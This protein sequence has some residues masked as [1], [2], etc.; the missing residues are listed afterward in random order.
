LLSSSGVAF[1]TDPP[2]DAGT[3]LSIGPGEYLTPSYPGASSS[4]GFL[5]PY[6]DAEY[7][8]RLY[9]NAS[10]L[11]GVY[12]YKTVG[13]ALGAAL[14]YDFTERLNTDDAR[15]RNLRDIKAT[16]RFKLFAD[17]TFFVFTGDF[18]VATDVA[19][20]GQGTLAQANLLV[21][22]PFIRKWLFSFGPGLT[23]ADHTYMTSFFTITPEQAAISPLRAYNAH[24]GIADLHL[25]GVISYAVSS[26]WS[27]GAST[28]A[29]RLRGD[30]NDSPVTSRRTQI[31]AI[32]WLTYKVK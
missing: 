32:G 31:M 3:N 25:N 6:I 4:R 12:A 14:Q 20:R 21:T 9:T 29:A 10:D 17:K 2:L 7:A 18:N 13:D 8:G 5:F 26:R 1:A 23:W 19:G 27:I 16:P 28:Y 15:F 24:A 11:I 22:I 30:A